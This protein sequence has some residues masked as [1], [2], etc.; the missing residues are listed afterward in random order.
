MTLG[1]MTRTPLSLNSYEPLCT[2]TPTL[3]TIRH[4]FVPLDPCWVRP[5]TLENED[6]K[7]KQLNS[8]ALGPHK[9][10]GRGRQSI[11]L[12]CFSNSLAG[13]LL[14]I[15][16]SALLEESRSDKRPSRQAA[17]NQKFN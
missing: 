5:R 1:C 8:L 13:R 14:S 16:P 3:L 7:V 15:P 6:G 17:R 2:Y 4:Y 9:G 12:P 10:E 11:W